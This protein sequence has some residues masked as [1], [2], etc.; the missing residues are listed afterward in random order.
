MQGTFAASKRT[1][2]LEVYYC[3]ILARKSLRRTCRGV[4]EAGDDSLTLGYRWSWRYA[5]AYGLGLVYHHEKVA[6]LHSGLSAS[7]CSWDGRLS[8]AS[9]Q[10][11]YPFL[12]RRS[13]GHQ[14]SE[15]NRTPTTLLWMALRPAA[16]RMHH[17][18]ELQLKILEKLGF[19]E[20]RAKAQ[21][22]F[23]MEAF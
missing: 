17:N 9:E 11:L 14:S 3:R 2:P 5:P 16:A 6:E 4:A 19:T 21:F 20:E 15:M 23:L 13:S 22:G 7:H 8:L 18:A 12:M 10:A 1:A